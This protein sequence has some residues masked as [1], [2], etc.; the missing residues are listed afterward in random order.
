MKKDSKAYYFIV[1]FLCIFSYC[2]IGQNQNVA[3][4]LKVILERGDLEDTAQFELLK[5]LAFNELSDNNLALQY[6]EKLIS[7]AEIQTDLTYQAHGYFHKG[8]VKRRSGDLDEA[9]EAYL[10]CIKLTEGTGNKILRG[11]AYVALADVFSV[12]NNHANA[13]LYYKKSIAVLR[14]QTKDSIPL[15]SAIL[16]TGDEY[17]NHGDYDSAL[18]YFAE[19]GEIFEK[20]DYP[21]GKAYN[22]GN[23]GVVYA[24]MGNN[25]RAEEN[26]NEAIRI[27]EKAEDYYPICFYLLII[28]DIY[29]QKEDLGSAINY[30]S[31]SLQLAK[32]YKLKQQISEANLKLSELYETKGEMGEA[33]AYYRDHITYRDSVNNI[34][35]VQKIADQTKDFEVNLREKE[36]DLLEKSQTLDRTYIIIAITLLTLAVVL[37]LYFRQRFL[38]TKLTAAERRKKNEL[39][40][41]DLLNTQESKALQSMVKGREDERKRLAEDLHNHFGNLLATI[42]VN[43]NSLEQESI[44][45]YPTLTTLVDQ[46]C[47]DIR[48]ISHELNMGISDNFGLVPALKE[49]TDHLKKSGNLQIEFSSTMCNRPMETDEEIT[50]YRIVQELVSNTLK[51]AQASKLSISLICF[52]E[53]NLINIIVHDN[54]RGFDASLEGSESSGMGINALKKM[55]EN[56]HGEMIVD[57]S[58]KKGTTVNIDL[59]LKPSITEI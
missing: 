20:V 35:T 44:P 32:Q 54:G 55:I 52:E 2:S 27:L 49:L 24:N 16:N 43:I 45:N 59:P 53:E 23:I 1:G 50:I 6:A 47:T 33:F 36:I 42:K 19:S 3:D 25:K 21:I 29:V 18:I 38:T 51:H 9:T 37:L 14:R 28:S 46:A 39:K 11:S 56:S 15:A 7:L 57:S 22:L 31:K 12:S 40:I 8:T 26:M 48:N 4:S 17:L 34:E 30:A 10:N 58:P 41:K 5:N 13:M